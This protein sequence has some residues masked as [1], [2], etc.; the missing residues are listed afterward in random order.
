MESERRKEHSQS[1]AH[2]K[3]YFMATQRNTISILIMHNINFNYAQSEWLCFYFHCFYFIFNFDLI[4]V[5]G[6]DSKC[7]TS[8]VLEAVE[9]IHAN[10]TS[11]K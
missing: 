4:T 8:E 1:H 9:Y 3:P 7:G 6:R 2:Q 11:Y 10:P 5:L